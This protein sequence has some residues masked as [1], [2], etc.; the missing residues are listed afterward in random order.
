V[1]GFNGAP[2]TNLKQLARMVETCT[3]EFLRFELEHELLVVL[4][5]ATAHKA[6]R[7]VLET[8]CIP[9]AKSADLR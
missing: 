7:D 3:E 5:R 6:T 2:V 8:H 4:K 9:E 1:L